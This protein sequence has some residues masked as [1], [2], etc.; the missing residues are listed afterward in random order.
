ML[1]QV[2]NGDALAP[3]NQGTDHYFHRIGD[4]HATRLLSASRCM[5]R[6]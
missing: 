1:R 4:F 2:P 5:D 3:S 6:L